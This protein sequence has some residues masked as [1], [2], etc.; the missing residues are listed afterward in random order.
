MDPITTG[1]DMLGIADQG[2][3][4]NVSAPSRLSNLS[5]III[6]EASRWQFSVFLSFAGG[7]LRIVLLYAR[8]M[9]R[10]A[11][12]SMVKFDQDATTRS[13]CRRSNLAGFFDNSTTPH[14]IDSGGAFDFSASSLD[15]DAKLHLTK[16]AISTYDPVPLASFKVCDILAL[17]SAAHVRMGTLE[18]TTTTPK[19]DALTH[20]TATRHRAR[21]SSL[22]CA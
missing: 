6:I 2:F 13:T 20:R 7:N 5:F 14:R 1:I 9:R 4:C 15:L 17:S 18:H 10:G 19:Y 22:Y 21:R 12:S 11:L 8:D 16:A 3:L